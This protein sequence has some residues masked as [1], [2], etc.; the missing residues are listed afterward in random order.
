VCNIE[1]TN[2]KVESKL[3]MVDRKSYAIEELSDWA[4]G[5]KIE[6]RNQRVECGRQ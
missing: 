2:G 1:Q 4:V 5:R 3:Q 6:I